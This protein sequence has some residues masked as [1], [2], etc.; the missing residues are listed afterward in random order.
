MAA[1]HGGTQSNGRVTA[2][3]R[4]TTN[5]ANTR[6]TITATQ[7]RL[8]DNTPISGGTFV[9][10]VVDDQNNTQSF[11]LWALNVV[12]QGPIQFSIASR[13]RKVDGGVDSLDLSLRWAAPPELAR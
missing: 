5:A 10:D 13:I 1:D 4:V 12:N 11:D 3:W 8:L 7:I 9:I 6:A 2:V